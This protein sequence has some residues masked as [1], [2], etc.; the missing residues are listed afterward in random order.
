MLGRLYAIQLHDL[1][2]RINACYGS[3]VLDRAFV[4]TP[5][6]KAPHGSWEN[7]KLHSDSVKRGSGGFA[8]PP[9]VRPC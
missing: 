1:P 7:S 2:R 3:L 9:F 4:P 8:L 5:E 6:S